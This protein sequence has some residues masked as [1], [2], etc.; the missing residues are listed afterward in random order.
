MISKSQASQVAD[1]V[2]EAGRRDRASRGGFTRPLPHWLHGPH[3]AGL[4]DH[5]RRACF[6]ELIRPG[7]ATTAL[8]ISAAIVAP[9][10]FVAR[11]PV[12]VPAACPAVLAAR[13]DAL[14]RE[15]AEDAHA[16]AARAANTAPGEPLPR[17]GA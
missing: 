9:T 14:R 10:I 13:H 4:S 5:Q 1:E 6:E 2:I 11:L 17:E 3:L 15:F 12:A 8:L 7:W 16:F